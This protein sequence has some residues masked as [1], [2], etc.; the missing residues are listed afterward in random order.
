MKFASRQ[1]TSVLKCN[2][3]WVSQGFF[4]LIHIFTNC[5]G[6]NLGK[7]VNNSFTLSRA[8][9]DTFYEWEPYLHICLIKP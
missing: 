7:F 4:Y 3:V 2:N 5:A 6:D 9:T 1:I 8:V